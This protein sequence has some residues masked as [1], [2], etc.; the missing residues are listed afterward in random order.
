MSYHGLEDEGEGALV[1]DEHENRETDEGHGESNG[2]RAKRLKTSTTTTSSGALI[3]IG[4]KKARAKD[5][6]SLASTPK[7]IQ[8]SQTAAN[9]GAPSAGQPGSRHEG[10]DAGEILCAGAKSSR[11][12]DARISERLDLSE[13]DKLQFMAVIMPPLF[14]CFSI[15][16]TEDLRESLVCLI[17]T[18]L[19]Q[20]ASYL[21]QIEEKAL[22]QLLID[23]IELV[24]VLRR[25]TWR[26][27]R[28][29]LHGVRVQ[30]FPLALFDVKTLWKDLLEEVVPIPWL[31]LLLS[32]I[33]RP[34]VAVW[35]L[36]SSS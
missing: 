3:P 27:I 16:G 29:P 34:A 19:E 32:V 36:T 15:T 28:Y 7:S 1:E 31:S 8:D 23:A 17:I 12:S 25:N 4:T 11:E 2:S 30:V 20:G 35:M 21:L 33:F 18:L 5:R 22:K 6:A 13:E 9:N 24:Q 14:S 26:K 10:R